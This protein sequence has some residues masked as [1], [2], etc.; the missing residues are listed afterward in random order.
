ML[1]KVFN[2]P[3]SC[4]TEADSDIADSD[5]VVTDDVDNSQYLDKA[6]TF[7]A[8]LMSGNISAG[9]ILI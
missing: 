5:S 7:D 4:H 8:Q 9:G 2:V 3:L 1:R 6:R